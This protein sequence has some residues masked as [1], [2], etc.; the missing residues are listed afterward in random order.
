MSPKLRKCRVCLLRKEAFLMS[1]ISSFEKVIFVRR[2][3]IA[4]KRNLS[5]VYR[6]NL[7]LLCGCNQVISGTAGETYLSSSTEHKGEVH[8]LRYDH[9]CQK[10]N[11]LY[12]YERNKMSKWNT[13]KYDYFKIYI[14]SMNNWLA[15]DWYW[16]CGVT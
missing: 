3:L 16:I 4:T 7:I 2:G 9:T 13:N 14:F 6:N 10:C 1:W 12:F 5:R 11:H 8:N 15:H